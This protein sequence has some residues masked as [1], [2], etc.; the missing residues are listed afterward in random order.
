M[1]LSPYGA[2]IYFY[3]FP[4]SRQAN[5]KNVQQ[6]INVLPLYCTYSKRE[7][8]SYSL[9]TEMSEGWFLLIYHLHSGASALASA[10]H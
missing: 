6:T 8:E 1:T 10:Q 4:S 7:T 3:I 5:S 2:N 9:E